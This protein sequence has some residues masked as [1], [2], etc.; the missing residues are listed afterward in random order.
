LD[1]EST[2]SIFLVTDA[3]LISTGAWVGQEPSVSEIR[4]AAFHSR[5]FNSAQSNYSTFD[6][7]LLAIIDALE[8]F[9]PV[10]SGCRFMILTDHKLLVVFPKQTELL[11]RQARWQN[12]IN[13]F[14]CAIQYIDA[15]KNMIANTFSRV[16]I[17][18]EVLPTL[19]DFIPSKI[20]S[21]EPT[22][23]TTIHASISAPTHAA[24]SSLHPSTAPTPIVTPAA[25][26][27]RSMAKKAEGTPRYPLLEIQIPKHQETG[28]PL[29]IAVPATPAILD[30]PL[31][32]PTPAPQSAVETIEQLV[33]DDLER[34]QTKKMQLPR[35]DPSNEASVEAAGWQAQHAIM[36]WTACDDPT[37]VIHR[38]S[39][40]YRKSFKNWNHCQYCN[41][42]GHYTGSCP[43]RLHDNTYTESPKLLQ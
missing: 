39:H 7:E 31:P 5:T 10:L 42:Y 2:E 22:A 27:T 14:M 29:A 20:D 15:Y 24:N 41:N 43:V 32:A 1:Y 4:P 17:N 9:R 36:Y 30:S 18:P 26:T 19:S 33:M 40:E 28:S 8:H 35:H 21:P 12:T 25:S 6:K 37:C 38:S 3:S 16:F 23:S 34:Y 11:D 13:H